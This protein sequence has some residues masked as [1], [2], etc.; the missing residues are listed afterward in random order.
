MAETRETAPRGQGLPALLEI[1]RRRRALALLPLAFVLAATVS[2]AF[3]LPSIWTA[4]RSSVARR[5]L[6]VVTGVG[7]GDKL[8]DLLPVNVDRR[9]GRIS[10]LVGRHRR[11]EI[12]LPLLHPRD[13]NE[14]TFHHITAADLDL[15]AL[16]D[17]DRAADLAARDGLAQALQETDAHERSRME[18]CS[19]HSVQAG[20]RRTRTVRKRVESAS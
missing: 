8:V 18:G 11:H 1:V 20:S 13:A 5:N 4:R 6:D 15:R 16:P 7:A 2:L 3:F 14:A 19:P 17:A 12:P 9:R 10:R